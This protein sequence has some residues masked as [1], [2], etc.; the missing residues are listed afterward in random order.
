MIID[1]GLTEKT[2]DYGWQKGLEVSQHIRDAGNDIITKIVEMCKRQ[3]TGIDDFV[4]HSE[5]VYN[6]YST[7]QLAL[8]HSKYNIEKLIKW[9]EDG[10]PET[11]KWISPIALENNEPSVLDVPDKKNTVRHN[12]DYKLRSFDGH[13]LSWLTDAYKGKMVVALITPDEFLMLATG[14]DIRDLKSKYSQENIKNLAEKMKKG[15]PIDTM[16]LITAE[17]GRVFTFEGRHRAMAAIEAG[18]KQIP[19]YVYRNGG[20][21]S[22]DEM[23]RF[24]QHPMIYLRKD[25]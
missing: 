18:I 5:H 21:H 15:T 25:R 22:P 9:S 20:S 17:D 13:N 1:L 19:V 2:I 14:G 8:Y 7:V 10:N 23:K 24:A 4:I 12:P 16:F 6:E 3:N 11:W